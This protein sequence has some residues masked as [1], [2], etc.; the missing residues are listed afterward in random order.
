MKNFVKKNSKETIEKLCLFIRE[1][2]TA[3]NAEAIFMMVINAA[4]V[5]FDEGL[6]Q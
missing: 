3:N 2:I 4:E 6:D 5:L 1:E